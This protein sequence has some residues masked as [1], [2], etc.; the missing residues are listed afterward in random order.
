MSE[1]ESIYL[2]H[3]ATTPLAAEVREAMEPFFHG[4]FGNASCKH[5]LGKDARQAIEESRAVVADFFGCAR[6]E[7]VFTG[8]GTEA[9]NLAIKGAALARRDRGKHVVISGVEHPSVTLSARFLESLGFEV[10]VAPASPTGQI[11]P[12]AVA[13]VLRKDTQ[14]VSV[15]HGNNEVGTINRLADIAAVVRGKRIAFH[16]DAI[17]TAGKI[18]T[19]YPFLGVDLLSVAGHKLYGP[20]GVGCLIVGRG[21]KLEPLLHGAGHEAGRRSGTENTAGIVGFAAA[22]KLARRH[23]VDSGERIVALRDL[24]HLRLAESLPGVVLNGALLDR[25]PS[26]LN[27]SFLGVSGAEL[28]ARLEGVTVATGPAC[29]DRSSAPSPTFQAMGLGP[30]RASSSLRISL[31]RGTTLQEIEKVAEDLIDAVN[32][33]RAGKAADGDQKKP[34]EHPRCPRCERPLRLEA[35]RS[36]AAIV[37]E[38]HPACRYEVALAEPTASSLAD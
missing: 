7:V 35:I 33:L 3:N 37:C 11:T 13:S 29:H 1:S 36:V 2:D 28:A 34:S 6:D 30:E 10:S 15:V 32:A 27:V 26:T 9:N 4:R 16:S 21:V 18:P 19:S 25:L 14:L 23:M 31:G 20:K 12:D 22:I 38:T 24:L 5:A 17:Q 8:G